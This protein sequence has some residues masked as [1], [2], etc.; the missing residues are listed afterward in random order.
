MEIAG[1]QP[2]PAIHRFSLGA[3]NLA[4]S[5]QGVPVSLQSRV[6]IGMPP[7]LPLLGIQALQTQRLQAAGHTG[8]TRDNSEQVVDLSVVVRQFLHTGH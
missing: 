6:M 3:R 5:G 7:Q 2:L 4:G 8:S 1:H